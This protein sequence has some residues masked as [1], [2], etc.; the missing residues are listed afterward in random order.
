MGPDQILLGIVM[1][2]GK[3]SS[4]SDLVALSKHTDAYKNASPSEPIQFK[5]SERAIERQKQFRAHPRYHE[6]VEGVKQGLADFEAGCWVSD[7]DLMAELF[8][9]KSRARGD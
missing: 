1:E 9:D 7:E 5:Q 2:Y 8:G 6:F 4:A 3:I